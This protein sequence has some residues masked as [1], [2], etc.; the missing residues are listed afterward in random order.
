MSLFILD[1]GPTPEKPPEQRRKVEPWWNPGRVGD[2]KSHWESGLSASQIGDLMGVTRNTIIG[3]AHRLGLSPRKPRVWLE[4]GEPRKQRK[5]RMKKVV[6]PEGMP[7]ALYAPEPVLE[8]RPVSI[9]SLQERHC[10]FIVSPDGEEVQY[11]GAQK[12]WGSYCGYHARM[13]YHFPTR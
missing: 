8:P 2:L 9:G 13:C 5:S 11:C 10:R 6:Y 12:A 4:A 3:K 1:A 7:E